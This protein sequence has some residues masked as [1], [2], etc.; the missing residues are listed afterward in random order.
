MNNKTAVVSGA[1]GGIGIAVS[2]A[3]YNAGYNIVLLYNKNKKPLEDE[4]S[5]DDKKILMI[6]GDL[7]KEC[8][9]LKIKE[10]VYATFHGVDVIVNNAGISLIKFFD[11][12]TCEEWDRVF[13]VN[14]KSAFMLTKAFIPEMINKKSG[15]I[16]NISSMWGISGASM[17]VC[18][19]A[20]KAA[21]IGMSKALAKE[22]GP[23]G[24]NVNVIAPGVIET[25][26]NEHISK[27]DMDVL[28]EDTPIN[29]IGKPE[30][31]ANAVMFLCDEKA[32]FITGEVI[33]V[34]GG[35]IL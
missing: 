30:D 27:E 26:M 15:N 3:L 4:F 13:D 1:S 28:I 33:K 32:S 23:S 20:S 22:L 12:T 18:Y 8:D 24:I 11:E 5:I 17:E 2:K 9:I 21:M 35:F 25:K 6:Q 34:D 16:I 29:R 10:E 14:V 7:S 31:I 19:S